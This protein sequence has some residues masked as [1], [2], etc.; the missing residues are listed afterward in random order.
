MP[1]RKR[2]SSEP[3][4]FERSPCSKCG[5]KMMLARIEPDTPDRDRRTYECPK[6]GAEESMVL[7]YRQNNR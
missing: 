2:I 7:K 1:L 5:A 6:C 3:A 4:P